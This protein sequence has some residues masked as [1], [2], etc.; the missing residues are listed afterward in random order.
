MVGG[1]KEKSFHSLY[2]FNLSR[3]ILKP[4]RVI[5]VKVVRG[6]EPQPEHNTGAAV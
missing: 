3:L 5:L 1:K 2:V 6:L 4:S